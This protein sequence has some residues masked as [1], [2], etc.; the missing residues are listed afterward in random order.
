MRGDYE[1][2][3]GNDDAKNPEEDIDAAVKGSS[4]RIDFGRHGRSAL[5]RLKSYIV[6]TIH[7]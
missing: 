4:V 5:K 3:R 2:N 1:D 6:K 7:E